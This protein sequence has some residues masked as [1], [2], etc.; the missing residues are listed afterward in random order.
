MGELALSRAASVGGDLCLGEITSGLQQL[1]RPLDAASDDVLVRRRSGGGI[2]MPREAVAVVR[3][4]GQL[5][6]GNAG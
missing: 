1:F 5:R 3:E 2:S 4:C 6:Q